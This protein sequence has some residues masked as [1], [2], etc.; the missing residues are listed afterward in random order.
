MIKPLI[1][2]DTE[3]TGIGKV[4]RLLQLAFRCDGVDV[5]ELYKPPLSINLMAMAVHHIT[6]KMVTDKPAFNESRE[7]LD[8]MM[9]SGK[10][11]I[12]VAHNAKFDLGMLEQEGVTFEDHICT[13]RVER[14]LDPK[15]ELESYKLQYLRYLYGMELEAEAHDAW[16]DILVLEALFWHQVMRIRAMA[17]CDEDTALITMLSVSSVPSIIRRFQFGKHKGEM[18]EDVLRYDRSYLEWLKR[19]KQKDEEPDED[20]LYTFEQLGV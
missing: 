11:Q 17:E 20:W 10:G 12:L 14:H 9:R 6:E 1:F 18:V 13:L 19:E 2:A 7:C 5:D 8:L 16:G 3:T 15:A 4:D